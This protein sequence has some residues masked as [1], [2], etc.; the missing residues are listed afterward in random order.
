MQKSNSSNQ[1]RKRKPRKRK[2]SIDDCDDSNASCDGDDK[3][4]DEHRND[5]N[6]DISCSFATK[7]VAAV[8]YT[9]VGDDVDDDLSSIGA[10]E[11]T[12]G[13]G[14]VK[15]EFLGVFDDALRVI[16]YWFSNM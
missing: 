12:N 4:G 15:Q 14:I 2:Q 9:L 16:Q 8:E 1:R 10:N 7:A 3:E 6:R 11:S 13:G 5:M